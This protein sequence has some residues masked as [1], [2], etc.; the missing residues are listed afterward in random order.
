MNSMVWSFLNSLIGRNDIM[1]FTRSYFEGEEREGFFIQPLMKRVWAAQLEVL[2]EIDNICKRH[3]IKYFAEWGTLLGAVRHKGYIP[4]DDDLDI[5]MLREDFVR[6]LHYAKKEIP[7][8]YA[9]VDL[10]DERFDELMARVMNSDR[11]LP[12]DQEFL[13]KFHG[14]PYGVGV[15]ITCLDHIPK[16][17][18]DEEILLTW[19]YV[20]NSLGR[21]WDS[22][23]DTLEN[24]MECLK[25]IE[26]ETGFHFNEKTSIKRQLLQLSDKIAAMYYDAES[27]E[28]TIMCMLTSD[29]DY[30]LPVSCYD[31]IIEVPFENTIIPIPAEYD[32]ILRLRYG[33]NYMTP[34]RDYDGGCLDHEYPYF[35]NQVEWLRN[36]YKK[37]GLEL[38]ECFS[39]KQ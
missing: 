15:D 38:P 22:D 18:E 32:R 28:V 35:L 21:N 29:P 8:G 13:K 1:E 39:W 37:Q 31:N 4:W 30:R 10:N 7:K 36:T 3:H 24:K 27:D 14:C 23:E 12:E 9:V 6:F 26:E 11:I 17:K 34:I 2:Q 20:T 33:D 5:G 16:N 25:L 19:L